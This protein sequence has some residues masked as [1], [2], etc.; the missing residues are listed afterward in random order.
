MSDDRLNLKPAVL[1][2]DDGSR[3]ELPDL[4]VGEALEVVAAAKRDNVP[5]GGDLDPARVVEV[6]YEE[7]DQ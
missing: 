3:A 4:T 2:L 6:G 7:V 5:I 1:L